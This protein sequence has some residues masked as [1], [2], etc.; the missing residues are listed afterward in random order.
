M[1]SFVK[2]RQSHGRSRMHDFIFIKKQLSNTST[3]T[4]C[5]TL[6]LTIIVRVV[7]HLF[8][9][10]IVSYTLTSHF[11]PYLFSSPHTGAFF[12]HDIL[13]RAT[14]PT[15]LIAYVHSYNCKWT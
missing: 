2:A 4:V 8:L 7:V 12:V 14:F 6:K 5:A 1:A 3:R 10:I 15:V 9:P 13:F 11:L